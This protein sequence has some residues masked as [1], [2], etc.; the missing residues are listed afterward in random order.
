MYVDQ[1]K[2]RLVFEGPES[3]SVN[4]VALPFQ[5]RRVSREA[6]RGYYR[7]LAEVTAPDSAG[8]VF[9]RWWAAYERGVAAGLGKAFAPIAPLA[10][11]LLV[12]ELDRVWVRAGDPY[13][14]PN[15]VGRHWV[16][17]SPEGRRLMEF[18]VPRGLV[19][20][21]VRQGEMLAVEVRLPNSRLVTVAVPSE[22]PANDQ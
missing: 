20:L 14:W 12:D 16:M 13:E 5:R 6:I 21:K 7:S 1:E 3:G 17:Y 4:E 19:A 18:S 8:I 2:A 22:V 11:Q 9:A 15:G 10:T